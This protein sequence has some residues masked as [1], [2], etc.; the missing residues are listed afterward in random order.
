METVEN[1]YFEIRQEIDEAGTER[2][3][4]GLPNVIVQY[5]TQENNYTAKMDV[6][7]FERRK[8]T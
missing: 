3:N 5:L 7:D 8:L 2:D 1:A 6:D 4:F